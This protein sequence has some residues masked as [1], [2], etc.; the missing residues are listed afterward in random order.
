MTG[1]N[2]FL[3]GHAEDDL[4]DIYEYIALTLLE[5]EIAKNLTRRITEQIA[6]LKDLP[7]SYAVYQKEPWGKRGLRRKNVGNY[8]ILFVPVEGKRTVVV[9][10]IVYGGRD[11]N[12]VLDDTPDIQIDEK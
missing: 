2:I 12:Q 10:R 5:P 7:Q 8:A 1:W 9:I 4:R 11:I 3:T 6:K